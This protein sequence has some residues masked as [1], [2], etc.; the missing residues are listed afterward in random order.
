MKKSAFIIL[1]LIIFCDF[2]YGQAQLS[3]YRSDN[4]SNRNILFQKNGEAFILNLFLDG[5]YDVMQINASGEE[6]IVDEGQMYMDADAYW[7]AFYYDGKIISANGATVYFYNLL[8]KST[9]EVKCDPNYEFTTPNYRN[10]YP[11]SML[12]SITEHEH[13]SRAKYMLVDYDGSFKYVNTKEYLS[14]RIDNI[15]LYQ[16]E[17]ST[18][19]EYLFDIYDL[20]EG[21]TSPLQHN[22]EDIHSLIVKNNKYLYAIGNDGIFERNSEGLID[23]IVVDSTIKTVDNPRIFSVKDEIGVYQGGDTSTTFFF[24]D[25]EKK[26]TND[27]LEIKRTGTVLFVGNVVDKRVF[28]SSR[29]FVLIVDSKGEIIKQLS[30]SFVGGLRLD[31]IYDDQ[32]YFQSNLGFV[33]YDVV[34]DKLVRMFPLQP[35]K[36]IVNHIKVDSLLYVIASRPSSFYYYPAYY[37]KQGSSYMTEI[38]PIRQSDNG[39][40]IWTEVS[41]IGSIG[42]VT[43]PKMVFTFKDSTFTNLISSQSDIS[44]VYIKPGIDT[45]KVFIY[46]ENQSESSLYTYQNENLDLE[47]RINQRLSVKDI[48]VGENAILFDGALSDDLKYEIDAKEL[49]FLEDNNFNFHEFNNDVIFGARNVLYNSADSVVFFS[50]DDPIQTIFKFEERFFILTNTL[51]ELKKNG[52]LVA[53]SGLE[54]F[55]LYPRFEDVIVLKDYVIIFLREANFKEAN[56]KFDGKDILRITDDVLHTYPQTSVNDLVYK[57]NNYDYGLYNADA[58]VNIP[59]LTD[60]RFREFVRFFHHEDELYTILFS[61]DNQFNFQVNKYDKAGGNKEQLLTITDEFREGKFDFINLDSIQ[62]VQLGRSI[63]YFYQ[64]EIKRIPHPVSHYFYRPMMKVLEGRLYFIGWDTYTGNQ[65]YSISIQNLIRGVEEPEQEA[66]S[67]NLAISPNPT[68]GVM[69]ISLPDSIDIVDLYI[70]NLSGQILEEYHLLTKNEEINIEALI[71]GYYIARI[72]YADKVVSL[73]FVKI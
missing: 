48:Y 68:S 42:F 57:I 59:F 23:T 55:E 39:F 66:T 72:H 35:D 69:R 62:F 33:R 6:V 11:T 70:L 45:S 28:I 7:S 21:Q 37:T 26:T 15:A 1:L 12:L 64:G 38:N 63:Y 14:R 20:D 50:G 32:I 10:A 44:A 67:S 43:N 65:L 58:D 17:N 24:V 27:V 53:I 51:Y 29:G 71:S 73:P 4:P 22:G 9:V 18:Y 16:R 8:D 19:N 31:M 13:Q 47:F 40:G 2:G 46:I 54:E 61:S 36:Q 49:S 52:D 41:T 30:A 60:I 34:K 56:F 25:I 3:D 5:K